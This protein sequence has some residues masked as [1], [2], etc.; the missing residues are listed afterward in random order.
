[1]SSCEKHNLC[2]VTEERDRLK[3]I[4]RG[5]VESYDILVDHSPLGKNE[6]AR[7]VL[8]G[9]FIDVIEDARAA[10]REL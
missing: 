4:V 6:I 5:L 1:M 3:E 2:A 9:A 8:R 7:G 10:I